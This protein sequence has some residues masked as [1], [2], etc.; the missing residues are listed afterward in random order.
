MVLILWPLYYSS[1]ATIVKPHQ[2]AMNQKIEWKK[3]IIVKNYNNCK[4]E[5]ISRNVLLIAEGNI[6]EERASDG[7]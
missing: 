4:R 5:M 2:F 7:Q 1:I 3:Q 6:D